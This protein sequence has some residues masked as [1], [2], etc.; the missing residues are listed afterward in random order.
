MK[1]SRWIL[2]Q[3]VSFRLNLV[4]KADSEELVLLAVAAL[5]TVLMFTVYIFLHALWYDTLS[6]PSKYVFFVRRE[7]PED[8]IIFQLSNI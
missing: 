6:L 7:F 8:I 2:K 1:Q 3:L 4:S 5:F